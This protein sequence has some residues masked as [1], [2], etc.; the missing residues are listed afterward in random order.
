MWVCSS[1]LPLLHKSGCSGIGRTS[2]GDE[3]GVVGSPKYGLVQ[4][5]TSQFAN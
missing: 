2:T 4:R 5:R 3:A 1:F